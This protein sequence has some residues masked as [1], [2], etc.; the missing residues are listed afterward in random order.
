MLTTYTLSGLALASIVLANQCPQ[1]AC[2]NALRSYGKAADFCTKYENHKKT[3]PAKVSGSC[4]T[5]GT[6]VC[7]PSSTFPYPEALQPCFEDST[8]A[9]IETACSECSFPSSSSSPNGSGSN[10][11]T[12]PAQSSLKSQG[13]SSPSNTQGSNGPGQSSSPGQG[14]NSPSYGGSSPSN[15]QGASG[16]GGS[17]SPGQGGSNSSSGPGSP[18]SQTTSCTP[19]LT[20]ITYSDT[21]CGCSKTTTVPIVSTVRLLIHSDENTMLTSNARPRISSQAPQG[22]AVAQQ[23]AHSLSIQRPRLAAL[24]VA[25]QVVG[26]RRPRRARMAPPALPAAAHLRSPPTRPLNQANRPINRN[27]FIHP[28]LAPALARLGLALGCPRCPLPRELRA[29]HPH[30][31]P[32]S[33][34]VLASP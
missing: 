10:A 8:L 1:N 6:C 21:S 2:T 12:S 20:T 25:H 34:L 9:D 23:P 27:P 30:P 4:E 18:G 14:G 15:T 3:Q 11:P 32:P 26:L 22:V 33:H 28:F 29:R 19:S 13:A 5:Q 17:N 7:P 24:A 31:V 16:P